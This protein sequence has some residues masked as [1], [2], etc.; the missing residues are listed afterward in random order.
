MKLYK[1]LRYNNLNIHHYLIFFNLKGVKQMKVS[2]LLTCLGEVFT[3]KVGR[4]L[5]EVLERLGC[6]VDF[7]KA[8][9]CCGQ[10][11]YN[12]GHRKDAIKGAKQTI[13]AFEMSPYVVTPSGSCAGMIHGYLDLF[14]DDAHWLER[15]EDLKAKTFEFTEFLVDV[16]GV[17]DIGAS[18]PK[19]VTYHTSCHMTRLLGVKEA[20]LQLLEKVEGIEML[21]LANSYDCCGFGGTF[22]VKM[23]NISEQ[24]VDEKIRHIED[25]GAEV[26]IGADSSCLMNIKGRIER[27]NKPIKVMHIAEVLNA[28]SKLSQGGK[29][30][31]H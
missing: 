8:Q 4:D 28:S 21:P 14:H 25:T 7:P 9:T 19:K 29:T 24:M 2:L 15:A 13:K 22:A 3:P 6:E 20:P 16:L 17:T 30:N 27:L 11:A 18:F 1:I 31:V 5:V 10:V 23:A 26:L 12:G